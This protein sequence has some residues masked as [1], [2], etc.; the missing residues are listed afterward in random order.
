VSLWRRDQLRILLSPQQVTLLRL[1]GG[2]ASRVCDKRIVPC[3]ASK[4]GE[5]SWR[6]AVNTLRAVLPEFD[7]RKADVFVLLSN[8]FA[9][10]MLVPHSDEISTANEE[11]ALV[12]HHFTQI[13]GAAAEHWALRLSDS[14]ERGGLRVACAIDKELP[15]SLR[16]LFQSTQLTLRSIQPYFM[17]AFNQWRHHFKGAAWFALVEQGSLCLARFQNNHWHSIKSIKTGNNWFRELALQLE[18][19]EFLSDNGAANAKIPIFIFAPGCS[20][21]TPAQVEKESV[22]LL[23]LLHPSSTEIVETPYAMAMVG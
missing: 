13:Y 16:A 20:E 12:R 3:Y 10:Y 2:R 5:S 4:P 8:H 7:A 23:R 22:Q 9:R 18:R 17:A 6:N 11:E 15:E 1:A 19:E 21:P 14:A